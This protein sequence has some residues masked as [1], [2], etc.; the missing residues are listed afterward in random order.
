MHANVHFSCSGR[1][2]LTPLEPSP[3]GGCAVFL[4]AL[5]C[6]PV[7]TARDATTPTCSAGWCSPAEGPQ[8]YHM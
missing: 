8:V 2:M 3:G 7:P 6:L 4:R 5:C 1:C